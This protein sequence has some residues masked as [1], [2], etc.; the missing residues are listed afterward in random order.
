MKF[1]PNSFKIKDGRNYTLKIDH[2]V[3]G[4][5]N[6]A[7]KVSR[8]TYPE[9]NFF[10]HGIGKYQI[11]EKVFDINGESIFFIPAG[12]NHSLLSIKEE[13]EHI[14]IWFDP[15]WIG[16]GNLEY[17]EECVQIFSAVKRSGRN[18][19]I[20]DCEN[21]ELTKNLI[22][23]VYDEAIGQKSD[24]E[25]M[26]KL[27]L[28]GVMVLI[29][30]EFGS[31]VKDESNKSSERSYAVDRTMEYICNYIS[32]TFTL[33]E[34]ANVA[35]MSP[36]HFCAAFKEING[37]TPWEYITAKKIDLAK[38]MLKTTNKPVINI[39]FECGYNN[40]ANF[41]RAF[42]MLMGMTPGEYRKK[43]NQE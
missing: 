42:K 21:F 20:P 33:K 8:H 25:K 35:C 11:G 19:I 43:Q 23:N 13:V 3:T 30:R 18:F 39:A 26:I 5:K 1:D 32:K 36:S 22:K 10:M 31:H 16:G 34:L 4:V 41:N 38:E 27:F 37:V 17:A 2:Y 28:S 24:F 15:C 12:E 29:S 9:I 14:N 40:A 6:T 7:D